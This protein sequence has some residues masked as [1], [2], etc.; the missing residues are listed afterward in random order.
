MNRF[1]IL[2]LFAVL[3]TPKTAQAAGTLPQRLAPKEYRYYYD[4]RKVQGASL[5]LLSSVGIQD[6]WQKGWIEL[7]FDL[8]WLTKP[9]L[10]QQVSCIPDSH[11]AVMPTLSY[12]GGTTWTLMLSARV[13]Y[14]RD[15]E[16]AVS[17]G[18]RHV[19]YKLDLSV[20]T[21]GALANV[22]L[23]KDDDAGDHEPFRYP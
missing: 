23:L 7:D 17:D 14:P 19:R 22:I 2:F 1:G 21:L 10:P 16:F 13:I 8:P 5:P 15:C 12:K 3:F 6:M 9:G 20:A 18:R 11:G 4:G